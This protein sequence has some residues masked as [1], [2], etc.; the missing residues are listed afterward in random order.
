MQVKVVALLI[1]V[2]FLLSGGFF[3]FDGAPSTDVLPSVLSAT[4]TKA[5]SRSLPEEPAQ[6]VS[7][8]AT[9]TA[10]TIE[11]GVFLGEGAPPMREFE[12]QVGIS[13][14]IE[15]IFLGWPQSFPTTVGSVCSSGKTLLIFWENFGH[16]LD[17][18][19]AGKYDSYLVS[20]AK[21]AAAY[22]CPIILSIFHEMNGNW[23]D[24]DGTVGQNNPGKIIASWRHVH[25]SFSAAN[26]KWAWVINSN[27]V[28]DTPENA[29]DSYYPGSAYVDYVGVDGFNFGSPWLSFGE[30]FDAPVAMLQK[31]KKP[32]YI[33]S[34][35]SAAG[36]KKA[37]WIK[38]AME[39][40]KTYPNLA[41]FVWFD[42]KQVSADFLIDSDPTSFSAFSAIVH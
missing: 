13:P 15:A 23:D 38:E 16:S 10:T 34:F 12:T 24:W 20:F 7:T 25:D 30:I 21:D 8:R 17:D 36:A 19:I 3:I 18:I 37:V 35:A 32:I 6:S 40:M 9:S 31:Y 4:S 39:H 5:T 29:A 1:L 41:G 26:V 11:W 2:A 22:R 27:S 28:P 14:N 33:S 42:E